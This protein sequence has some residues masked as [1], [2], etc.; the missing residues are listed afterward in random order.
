MQNF[1]KFISLNYIPG[2]TP[3]LVQG[4]KGGRMPKRAL[5]GGNGSFIVQDNPSQLILTL[6]TDDDEY[7]RTN[8]IQTVRNVLDR[9]NVTLKLRNK[10]ED[11]FSTAKFEI[12]DGCIN[13]LEE[14]IENA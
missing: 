9:R 6:K 1:A 14:I 2:D 5:G 8:I 10:L 7:I 4:I 11:A 13:N 12:S 3:G